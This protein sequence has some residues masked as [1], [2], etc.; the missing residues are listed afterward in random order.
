MGKV[1]SAFQNDTRYHLLGFSQMLRVKVRR[2]KESE[3]STHQGHARKGKEMLDLFPVTFMSS[4][5]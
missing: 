5:F 2:E 1:Q 4:G 3:V